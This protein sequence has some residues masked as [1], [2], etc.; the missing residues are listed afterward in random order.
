MTT[1]K[2]PILHIACNCHKQKK[3]ETLNSFGL[4][5]T[6]R[7]S[8][9]C[10]TSDNDDDDVITINSNSTMKRLRVKFKSH[11][12]GTSCEPSIQR[13]YPVTVV[14]TRTLW[15]THQ[16]REDEHENMFMEMHMN[17]EKDE[18]RQQRQRS[19]QTPSPP[20]APN[21]LKRAHSV[22]IEEM[23]DEIVEP[24]ITCKPIRIHLTAAD[25]LHMLRYNAHMSFD[26]TSRDVEL[27]VNED[28]RLMKCRRIIV[29]DKK[30][31]P[32]NVN[33][34]MCIHIAV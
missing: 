2:N 17:T 26:D 34:V 29:E 27:E 7:K 31:L 21:R 18:T 28:V 25:K 10:N 8:I 22:P 24:P 19:N 6:R 9:E 4:L 13:E 15:S 14:E 32:Q 33:K 30:T 20:H 16:E 12:R 3:I 5:T 1:L 23:I 11:T